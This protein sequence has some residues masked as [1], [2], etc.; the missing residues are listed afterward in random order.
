[1]DAIC[2]VVLGGTSLAGGKANVFG[3]FLGCIIV[4]TI[5]NGLTL[6]RVDSNWQVVAKGLII[7]LAVIVDVYTEKL[8][9]RRALA[10]VG[11]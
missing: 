9:A 3:T 2:A 8:T 1:M 6:L 5:T 11:K 4:G 7:I 10:A